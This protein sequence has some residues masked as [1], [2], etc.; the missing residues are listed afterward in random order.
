MPF[1]GACLGAINTFLVG[2]YLNET[3]K[4]NDTSTFD[5]AEHHLNE[6]CNSYYGFKANSV[7]CHSCR[8]DYRRNGLD[9]CSLCPLKDQNSGLLVLAVFLLILGGVIVVWMTINDAGKAEKR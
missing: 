5:Y 6:E 7:L 8:D 1:P 2:K 4:D 3:T 9:R